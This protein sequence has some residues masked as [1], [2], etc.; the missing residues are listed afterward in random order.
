VAITRHTLRLSR[1]LRLV[2]TDLADQ[3]TRQLVA[4]WVKAWD[5]LHSGDGST[6]STS[7]SRSAPAS[8]PRAADPPSHPRP[9]ALEH[10]G[11]SSCERCPRPRGA[12]R[13]A[14]RRGRRSRRR[15]PGPAD[16]L[17]DAAPAGDM[18]TLSATFDRVSHRSDRRDRRAQHQADHRPVPA[19]VRRGHRGDGSGPSSAVSRSA[20]TRASPPARCWPAS[21]AASTAASPGRSRSPAPRS[22]TPTAPRR[23]RAAGQRRRAD[24]VGVAGAARQADLPVVLGAVTVSCTPERGRPA[25]TTSRAAAPGSRKSSRGRT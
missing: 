5:E 8:G 3:A 12:R 6:P 9:K 20:T 15:V 10:A 2:V 21:S 19:A 17:P 14:G 1:E 25:T 7:C 22:S 4:A 18:A 23:G 11:L 24:R 13:R 16:R